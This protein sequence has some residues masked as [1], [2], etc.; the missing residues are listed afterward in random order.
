M[1][2]KILKYIEAHDWVLLNINNVGYKNFYLLELFILNYLKWILYM[3][4]VTSELKVFIIVKWIML[5]YNEKFLLLG[6]EVV[7]IS[8][9]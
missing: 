2:N 4:L 5:F 6:I 8:R 3:P 1:N 9:K 7:A